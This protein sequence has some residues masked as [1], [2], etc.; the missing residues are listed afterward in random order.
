M[1]TTRYKETKLML[2]NKLNELYK[3]GLYRKTQDIDSVNNKHIIIS[4]KNFINFTSNDYLGLGQLKIDEKKMKT[5]LEKF[6]KN[7][8]SSRLISGN[9][10]IYQ[11]LEESISKY[12]RFEDSIITNSGYDAN[13]AIFQIFKNEN[14]VIFSD[15]KNHASII[16]GI[17][18]SGL[19]KVIYKHIDYKDLEERLESSENIGVQKVIVSDSIF[20]TNG[21]MAN[22]DKLIELK[23]KYNAILIIDDSHHLGLNFIKSYKGIDIVTS[24]LSKAFG[25]HGGIILCTHEI[26][27]LVVNFG[28]PIIY[29]SSLPI[30]N[31]YFIKESFE[32]LI[33]AE[34]RREYLTNLIQYFNA[35]FKR[36]F[37]CQNCS[38]SSIKNI[39]FS[40]LDS[41]SYIYHALKEKQILVSY[42]RYPTV[43]E[44]TIRISLSYFHNENDIDKL[45]EIISKL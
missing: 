13:L 19:R 12:F 33:N 32:H 1:G 36:L 45:L 11:Y 27:K 29:T 37:P 34:T 41:A 42:L 4:E 28:R 35:Q 31:L 14:Y 18:L 3:N 7:L 15:E 6:S 38:N 39:T 8:S 25:A 26:K 23:N 9:S 10:C 21:N 40:E 22:M 2:N 24:S 16:D 43:E 44:P 17:K 5:F 30:Y 20:S